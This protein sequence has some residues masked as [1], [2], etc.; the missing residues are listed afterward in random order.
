MEQFDY[1]YRSVQIKKP[2]ARIYYDLTDQSKST[3]I[4]NNI[5]K[6]ILLREA[7]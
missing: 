1:S 5:P 6:T 4:E 2:Y 3:M 7:S